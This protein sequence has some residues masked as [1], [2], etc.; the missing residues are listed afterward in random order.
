MVFFL[1]LFFFCL[2]RAG[3]L[4]NLI[5]YALK[6]SPRLKVYQSMIESTKY[7]GK[8]FKKLTKPIPIHRT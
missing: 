7:K 1:I 5:D 2:S 8:I 4:E 6:N 3:E